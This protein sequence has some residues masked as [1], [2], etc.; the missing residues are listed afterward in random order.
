MS[1]NHLTK[2]NQKSDN[3]EEDDRLENQSAKREDSQDVDPSLCMKG[4]LSSLST[5]NTFSPS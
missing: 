2:N 1:W 5:N 3:K 4:G